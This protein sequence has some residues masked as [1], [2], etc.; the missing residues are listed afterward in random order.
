MKANKNIA[1]RAPCGSITHSNEPVHINLHSSRSN[2]ALYQNADISRHGSADDRM[3][4]IHQNM[5]AS[6]NSLMRGSIRGYDQPSSLHTNS[7]VPADTLTSKFIQ[8]AQMMTDE[9]MRR[10]IRKFFDDLESRGDKSS[11]EVVRAKLTEVVQD[12][13]GKYLD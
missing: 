5:N 13:D 4:R 1:K 12:V 6:Q 2:N 10:S 7:F 3:I 11:K 8:D 9:D